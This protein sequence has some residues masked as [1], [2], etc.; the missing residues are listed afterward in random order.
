MW[1]H[2]RARPE[3]K[4]LMAVDWILPDEGRA[5]TRDYYRSLIDPDR[6]E[7]VIVVGRVV[8]EVNVPAGPAL[9][10]QEVIARRASRFPWRKIRQQNVIYT[11]FPPGCSDA[12]ELTFSTPD[13]DLGDQLTADAASAMDSFRVS[14]GDPGRK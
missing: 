12:I 11:V 10:V 1:V 8:D 7:G 5:L 13:A 9:L 2:D 3:V 6:R 14:L 4:G